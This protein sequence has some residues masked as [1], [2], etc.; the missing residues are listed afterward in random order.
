MID[1]QLEREIEKYQRLSR[2]SYQFPPS[3]ETHY[4]DSI[5]VYYY[6][7]DLLDNIYCAT[8]IAGGAKPSLIVIRFDRQLVF[9]QFKNTVLLDRLPTLPCTTNAPQN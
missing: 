1:L 8:L 9:V 3:I 6:N 4:F 5:L 7:R 2:W